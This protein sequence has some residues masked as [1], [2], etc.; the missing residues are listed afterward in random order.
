MKQNEEKA[1]KLLKTTKE[2]KKKSEEA[3]EDHPF[4]EPSPII[5]QRYSSRFARN[6]DTKEAQQKDNTKEEL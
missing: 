1:K 6:L 5:G 4:K 2:A 3:F